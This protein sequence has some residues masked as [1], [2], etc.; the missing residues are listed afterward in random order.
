MG[1]INPFARVS[2]VLKDAAD[3][4]TPA[5]PVVRNA[6]TEV[7]PQQVSW[8]DASGKRRNGTPAERDAAKKPAKAD[9]S[10]VAEGIR[11]A[12]YKGM[13]E[14]DAVK[15]SVKNNGLKKNDQDDEEEEEEE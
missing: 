8:V 7:E 11:T 13:S 9:P 3:E 6:P 2:K 4:S 1:Q 12:K 5:K 15:P 14:A 10:A